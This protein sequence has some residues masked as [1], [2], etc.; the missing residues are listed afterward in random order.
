MIKMKGL[1]CA[2]LAASITLLLL[3]TRPLPVRATP[4]IEVYLE[5]STYP[6][7][8]SNATA[9]T[10]FNV[11]VWINSNETF[12]LMMWQVYLNYNDS[13]I[14]ITAGPKYPRG[15]PND[16]QSGR[17]W[18]PEYVLYGQ[19]GG[20]I[21]NPTYYHTGTYGTAALM[22]GDLVMDNVAITAGPKKLC[23][24]EFNISYVD[25]YLTCGL[26]INNNDTF[27][28]DFAGE[29]PFTKSDGVYI[30]V[31]EPVLMILLIVMSAS[32]GAAA[33]VKIRTIKKPK[34]EC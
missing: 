17:S 23:T 27:L 11:T 14:N 34:Q 13:L 24:L 15:W 18:D 32:I 8:S 31:P 3:A 9:G 26:E 25:S 29:I 30:Y 6:F 21:G 19:S 4:A 22:L 10:S 2:M 12:N 20:A 16:N 7:D 33:L 1:T 5:P 28:Y